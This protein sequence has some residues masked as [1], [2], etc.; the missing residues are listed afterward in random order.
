MGQLLS[1][2][3]GNAA[4]LGPSL[5]ALSSRRDLPA[6]A[7]KVLAGVLSLCGRMW[8]PLLETT[9]NDFEQLLFKRAERSRVEA[10]QK[11]CFATL[12]EIK[13]VRAQIVPRFL[14]SLE[15]ALARIDQDAPKPRT[16][17]PLVDR[18]NWR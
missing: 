3:G 14:E 2:S 9:A 7:Q 10:D 8:A 15:D 5:A 6:R 16:A 4:K 13:R 12:R 17:D 18:R 11:R 1:G